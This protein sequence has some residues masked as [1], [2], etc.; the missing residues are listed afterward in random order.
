MAE[1]PTFQ[2]KTYTVDAT[3][4]IMGRMATEIATHLIGKTTASYVPYLDHGDNVVVMNASKMKVSGKKMTGKKY[5]KYSGYPGGITS[6]SLGT[7]LEKRPDVLL[8]KVV[9]NM[10]PK[11]RLRN[12]RMTRLTVT[13]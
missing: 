11:N 1:T 4:K 10:L 12:K 3:G 5:H 2:R 6:T 9:Y 7:L 13:P 8:K